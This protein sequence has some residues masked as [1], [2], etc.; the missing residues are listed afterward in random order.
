MDLI[1]QLSNLEQLAEFTLEITA[2]SDKLELP[3]AG[4]K[5]RSLATLKQFN[6]GLFYWVTNLTVEHF[7]KPLLAWMPHLDKFTCNFYNKDKNQVEPILKAIQDG[8][9][10]CQVKFQD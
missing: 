3:N 7:A 10:H 8:G 6:L 1:R 2:F 9:V 5:D 4:R